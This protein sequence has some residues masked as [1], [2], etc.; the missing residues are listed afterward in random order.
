MLRPMSVLKGILAVVILLA[1]PSWGGSQKLRKI[2]VA[3]PA[4]SPASTTFMVAKERG[5]YRDES[6]EA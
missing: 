6:L 3:I 5:Y 2:H 4:V 1:F